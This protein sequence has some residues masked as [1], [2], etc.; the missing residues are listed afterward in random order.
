MKLRS[1]IGVHGISNFFRN[2]PLF[3]QKNI[4]FLQIFWEKCMKTSKIA[5]I[6]EKTGN[7]PR[8]F[9]FF[10]KK[11]KKFRNSMN[12]SLDLIFT[13]NYDLYNTRHEDYETYPKFKTNYGRLMRTNW[14]VFFLSDF[15]INFRH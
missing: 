11:S 7:F 5:K 9:V 13:V 2:F 6:L 3:F 14:A 1:R 12:A 8:K 10:E 15:I 4:D